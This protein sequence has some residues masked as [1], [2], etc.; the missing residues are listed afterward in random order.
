[1][2]R[3]SKNLLSLSL[4]GTRKIY[5]SKEVPLLFYTYRI[6]REYYPFG[7]PEGSSRT[8]TKHRRFS[9]RRGPLIP[10]ELRPAIDRTLERNHADWRCVSTRGRNIFS[11]PC[12]ISRDLT[13]CTRVLGKYGRIKREPRVLNSAGRRDIDLRSYLNYMNGLPS[14]STP[15]RSISIFRLDVNRFK[16]MLLPLFSLLVVS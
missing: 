11:P 13:P 16:S 12:L 3:L 10:D 14:P 4:V 2:S 7:N 9:A 6:S 1:M 8:E 5:P 15:S